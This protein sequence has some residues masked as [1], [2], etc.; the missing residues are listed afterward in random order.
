MSFYDILSLALRNLRQAKLRTA[1]TTLGVSIG[2]AS[3]AGMVSLGVGLQEQVVGRFLQ[4]G[5]FDAITVV[6][7]GEFGAAAAFVEGR[8]GF[9]PGAGGRVGF[10]GTAQAPAVK[11]DP[12]ALKQI[13]EME[14]VREVYPNVRVPTQMKI[15]E[16]SR[17]VFLTG[18]PMSLKTEGA[19]QTFSYGGFFASDSDHACVLNLNTAKQID[20]QN[21]GS[22]IG[23]TATLS[24]ASSRSDD[25]SAGPETGFQVRR[26]DMECRIAGIVERDAT[27]LPFGGGP[28]ASVMIPLGVAEKIDAEI[29]TDTQSFLR[30]PSVRKTYGAVTVKVKQAKFT[31]D[32]EDRIRKM[33]F[34]A[35]SVNDALRGAK[36]A[37]IILDI[38]LTLIG[39]IALA[40]SSLG[41][42]N[43]M[44][45][46]ILER[47]R[48][49]G[50]MKAVG[51]SDGH[52]RRIFL[53]E[54]SVIGVMGGVVGV[55]IGWLVGQ[56][57]NLGV[58]IYIRTQGGTP[59]TF[60]FLPV[61]LIASAIGFSIFVSLIAG[62]YPASRAA[63][64]DPIQALRHD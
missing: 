23:K 2:I 49:I 45:M 55:A 64:L 24:Y 57:I 46:S 63:Q 36:N 6:N 37:F 4:A 27:A 1:L 40:V 14:N 47:T 22:L 59:G 11:L 48:E 20:E 34:S 58:N 60:F 28:N 21:P 12:D 19:F 13:S 50:I 30:D 39:S 38:F 3:L 8:G 61:W 54:A 53:I 42:V 15:G 35:I 41:I 25:S 5:V 16:F 29:V 7:P 62:S 9:Q 56:V 43:T 18:V 10:P 32:V 31:Q 52:I 33:G 51:A 17:L 44:V 26:V